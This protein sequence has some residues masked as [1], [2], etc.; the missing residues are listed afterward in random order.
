MHSHHQIWYSLR[1]VSSSPPAT[2]NELF[3]PCAVEPIPSTL[4]KVIALQLLFLFYSINFSSL[5]SN[6]VNKN[7]AIVS[8]ILGEKNFLDPIP[9]SRHCCILLPLPFTA[10]LPGRVVHDNYLLMLTRY[11]LPLHWILLVR[12]TDYLHYDKFRDQ[13]SVQMLLDHI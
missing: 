11:Y 4:L 7:E 3:L 1:S 10:K 9:F 13:G 6:S 8:S 12:V 2:R 5:L